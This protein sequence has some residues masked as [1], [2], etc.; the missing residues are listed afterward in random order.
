VKLIP[1]G[2]FLRDRYVLYYNAVLSPGLFRAHSEHCEAIRRG[3]LDHSPLYMPGDALF[4]CTI[5]VDVKPED[6]F[7]AIKICLDNRETL[8]GTV[9]HIQLLEFFPV[10]VIHGRQVRLTPQHPLL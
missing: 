10:K 3:G 8:E 5:A 2:V 1:F 9:E 6:L 4:H 7:R